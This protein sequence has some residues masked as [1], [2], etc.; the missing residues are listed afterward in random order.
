MFSSN[1]KAVKS[2]QFKLGVDDVARLSLHVTTDVSGELKY[3]TEP[4]IVHSCLLTITH[5]AC[6][7]GCHQVHFS[8][9]LGDLW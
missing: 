9:R 7:V 2:S 6:F 4:N 1:A 8:G 5:S 3:F